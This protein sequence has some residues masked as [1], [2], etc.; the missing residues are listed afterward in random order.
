MAVVV[1]EY[2]IGHHSGARDSGK[3]ITYSHTQQTG[4]HFL[5]MYNVTGSSSVM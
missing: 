1:L 5:N 4:S 3:F 2:H